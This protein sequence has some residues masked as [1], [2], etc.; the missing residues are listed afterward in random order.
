M[1]KPPK[2]EQEP[3]PDPEAVA[4]AKTERLARER[5]LLLRQIAATSTEDL[6][7]Q[8][9]YVL[10][11]Y[12]EARDSD[13]RLTHL[14]WETFY[15]EYVDG[16]VLQLD[17]MK[18]LPREVTITRTRAKIQNEYQ[19][20]QASADVATRRRALR[21]ET[22]AEVV[23][24]KPGPPVVSI[25]A[26][27]SSQTKHRFMVI[28]SVWGL[29]VSRL[30]RVVRELEEWKRSQRIAWEFKFSELS[31]QKVAPAEA[32]V[33]AAMEHSGLIG[34]KACVVDTHAASSVSGEERLY[35]L[36]YELA[37]TGMDHE[38]KAGRVALPRGL[39][40]VKDAS[41]EPDALHLPELERHLKV[42]CHEYF[43]DQVRVEPIMTGLSHESPLLQLADL[44]AG[45][46]ARKFNKE[47]EVK[48]AK[49]RFADFFETLAGF[50]FVAG[51]GGES[52]FVYVHRLA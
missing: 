29:D 19:L 42:A 2:A 37:M 24:D 7:A 13:L 32:F 43:A 14:V 40:L 49:D 52:D 22:S 18:H 31:H 6:R 1:A 35:R 12:P 21:A 16:G 8:V 46:V 50:D 25:F 30:W 4:Q 27:E 5:D 15:S 17:E 41:A 23:A 26:D 33:K 51:G 36:Y 10:S 39:H 20:F 47:G 9:G 28:G 34:L 48:N 3:E 11:L 45:S 44:F 38:I